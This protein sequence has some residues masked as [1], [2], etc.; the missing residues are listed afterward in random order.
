MVMNLTR[1]ST[2]AGVDYLL[3]TIAPGDR[4]VPEQGGG[5]TG[6]YAQSG[7]PP[8]RWWGRGAQ[9]AD[10]DAGNTIT[11]RG[12]DRFFEDFER[13]DTGAELGARPRASGATAGFDLMFTIPRSSVRCG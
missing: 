11:G 3:K 8:G 9:A 10:V 2:A 6:C 13:P 7:T 5:F 1:L 4:R 12:A